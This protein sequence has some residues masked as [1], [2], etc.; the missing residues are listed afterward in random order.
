MHFHSHVFQ[1]HGLQCSLSASV[2]SMSVN[3]KSYVPHSPEYT[4][5]LS[6]KSAACEEEDEWTL[7]WPQGMHAGGWP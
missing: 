6:R 5:A 7:M 4:P 2:C 1:L 3:S